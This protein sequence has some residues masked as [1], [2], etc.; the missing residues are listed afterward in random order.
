M[1]KLKWGLLSTARINRAV[2]PPIQLSKRSELSGVASRD[3]VKAQAYANDWGLPRAYGS[4]EAML[5]DP[6][7]NVVYNPLPNHLHADWSI[8]CAEAGK[9]VL[10]EKPFAL[11]VAEVDR[12]AAAAQANGVVIAEA[13]MYKHHPQ[14]LKVLDLLAQRAIGDLIAIKG[15]FT[16]MLDRAGD[17]R[18]APDWGGGSIWDVGCYPISFA[19][20]I[21]QA[22]PVEV[23]GWQQL[24][25]SGVDV[26]FA[27][28]LRFANGVVAQI[29]CGF[30]S[31]YRTWLEVVGT[32]GSLYI[33]KPFKPT[34]DV[35]ISLNYEDRVEIIKVRDQ[36]LYQG[37]IEDMERAVLDG[38]PQRIPLADSR[39]VVAVIIALL[40]SA[41]SGQVVRL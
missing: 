3:V 13:F 2:M 35:S 23:F 16:F 14:T 27:G 7:I 30:S 5:A 24:G 6:D 40:E 20:L 31:P 1:N 17:V 37:E 41:R 33:D 32:Q 22:A 21:A 34:G 39:T 18:W 8:K 25:S 38:Q 9:H 10:C 15:A 4:Y 26:A 19:C 29:E 12:V 36:E 28:Q 11:S